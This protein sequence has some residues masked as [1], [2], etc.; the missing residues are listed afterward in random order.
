MKGNL[1][2]LSYIFRRIDPL[3]E[4][5]RTISCYFTGCFLII[6]VPRLKEGIKNSKYH[7]KPGSTTA[8]TRIIMGV[9]KRVC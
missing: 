2:H 1:P 6:E 3:G 4:E 9:T 8:C 5:F 7:T